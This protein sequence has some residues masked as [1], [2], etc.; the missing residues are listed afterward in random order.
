MEIWIWLIALAAG[1]LIMM[2]AL[3]ILATRSISLAR[4]LKPFYEHIGRFKNTSEQY[5]EALGL[6]TGLAKAEQT[7]AN[8]PRGTKS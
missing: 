2:M 4:R 5:P 1:A 7:R 6:L 3:L 8:K